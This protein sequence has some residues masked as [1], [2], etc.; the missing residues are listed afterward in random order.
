MRHN[1][2]LVI[3]LL[4]I[5]G[6][7]AQG[8]KEP[9]TLSLIEIVDAQLQM[10]KNPEK[11][12][13]GP[14]LYLN[15]QLNV[16]QALSGCELTVSLWYFQDRVRWHMLP[17]PQESGA[18]IRVSH[19]W[20]PLNEPYEYVLAGDYK[21]QC[22]FSLE[23]QSPKVRPK[24]EKYL[25]G[26]QVSVVERM[27]SWDAELFQKEE[28]TLQQ[29][30]REKIVKVH[31]LYRDLKRESQ[32]SFQRLDE[33]EWRNWLDK[34][35]VSLDTE[36]QSY[37]K[38]NRGLF[39]PRHARARVNLQEYYTLLARFSKLVSQNIYKKHKVQVNARDAQMDSFGLDQVDMVEQ[40]LKRLLEEVA[41]DLN[42][43]LKEIVKD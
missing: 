6:S 2:A 14:E 37:E 40:N 34:F 41:K 11:S 26:R 25:K 32:K 15:F 3:L 1:I 9:E 24:I 36:V 42:L 19:R 43:N 23:N 29:F 18:K 4:C 10:E 33:R 5:F 38:F 22:S 30:H 35:A 27:I 17:V 13:W 8:Q 16:K 28:Q 39:S 20:G 21:L 7:G 12:P 31:Q